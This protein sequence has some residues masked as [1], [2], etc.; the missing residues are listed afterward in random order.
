MGEQAPSEFPIPWS[1]LHQC[2]SD[3]YDVNAFP[4]LFPQCDPAEWTCSEIMSLAEF[5]LKSS[6][7]TTSSPFI[8]FDYQ[9]VSQCD[10]H[11]GS[12]LSI[13][14]IPTSVGST[15]GSASQAPGVSDPTSPPVSRSPPSHIAYTAVFPSSV[16]ATTNVNEHTPR[17]TA[18]STTY[19]ST[20]SS[21]SSNVE[22]V[23]V[24]S[25]E[26][27][28][29]REPAQSGGGQPSSSSD[30]AD[31]PPSSLSSTVQ[32]SPPKNQESKSEPSVPAVDVSVSTG[33]QADGVRLEIG[34]ALSDDQDISGAN[35]QH[36]GHEQGSSGRGRRR[37][38]GRG[39]G[40][41]RGGVPCRTTVQAGVS[42]ETDDI[43][44][45]LSVESHVEW[46][47][48]EAV[49]TRKRKAVEMENVQ[50]CV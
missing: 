12:S 21:S 22:T 43:E 34:S 42:T 48:R 24:T 25:S 13:S 35:I 38:R 40:R 46:R 8:F 17:H 2:P 11:T 41:G 31:E 37:G 27:S 45:S 23:E 19:A 4:A 39:K 9:R 49:V 47:P 3:Y 5:M 6:S 16:P 7:L 32:S 30:Q 1:R 10:S 20:T 15:K 14:T 28:G 29:S 26:S 50:R 36:S 44:E 33:A 18:P